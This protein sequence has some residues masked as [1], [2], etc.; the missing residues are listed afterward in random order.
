MDAGG[1]RCPAVSHHL[2]EHKQ[3]LLRVL[4]RQRLQ[5]ARH[6]V[7]LTRWPSFSGISAGLVRLCHRENRLF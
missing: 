7:G 6:P 5:F 3:R 1:M 4:L 2:S